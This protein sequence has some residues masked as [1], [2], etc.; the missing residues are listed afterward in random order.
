MSTET[1][2]GYHVD[3]Q[4]LKKA[5]GDYRNEGDALIQ[6]PGKVQTGVG[7]GQVGRH[8]SGI[9]GQYHQVFDAFGRVLSSMG[10]KVIEVGGN[11]GRTADDY[12]K[13][14]SVN[15]GELGSV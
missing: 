10:N 4:A 5:A 1:G 8:F 11:L 6:A 13:T 12:T 3:P 15:T 9:V 7:S 14:E 2:N